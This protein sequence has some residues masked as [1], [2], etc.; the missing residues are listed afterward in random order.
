M[1]VVIQTLASFNATNLVFS[2][3]GRF[4]PHKDKDI[5][6]GGEIGERRGLGREKLSGGKMC[7]IA[8]IIANDCGAQLHVAEIRKMCSQIVYR[9]PDDEGFYVNGPVGLGMRRLSIIDVSG[10]QQPIHNED[11]SVWVVFNGEIYNFIELRRELQAQGHIFYT[12]SD[13]EVIVHAYEAYGSDCVQRLRGM[14]AF[15]LYDFRNRKLLLARD[16]LG[17]KPLHYAVRNGILYFA[18]EIK[19]L[20]AVVP[21]FAMVDRQSIAQFFYFGYIPDPNT[22]FSAVRKLPPGYWLEF[23]DTTIRLEQYWDLPQF[24]SVVLPEFECLQQLENTFAE[25][26]RIRLM[27]EVPLGA[28]LSGGVDSSTVVAMMAKVSTKP[29][30]TFSIRFPQADFNE[31][32]HARSVASRFETEHHELEVN[33]DLWSTLERLTSIIDEPFADSSVIPTYHVA[34]MARDHVTVV[35]SG[36]GGDELFAGYDN[37]VINYRRR[38]LDFVPN[39]VGPMYHKFVYPRIPIK[40]RNRKLVYTFVLGS[41]E[42]FVE[43]KSSLPVY[44]P[45]LTVLSPEFVS[46]IA[47]EDPAATIRRYYDNAPASDLVSRMQYVDAKTYLT[48]DVLT[49]VDRMSMACSLEVRC[50][51]LDHVFVELAARI[52]ISMKLRNGTRKYL[53]RRLAEKLGVPRETLYRRKQGFALPLKHWMRVEMK[54]EMT[55]VL[56]EP[57][58]LQR[59]YFRKGAVERMLSE[60]HRGE[61]DHAP[62]LWQLLMFEFWHRNYLER[63]TTPLFTHTSN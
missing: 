28:L 42:R 62:A 14:F 21:E 26:V 43:G 23:S 18:S 3:D 55:A 11:R 1:Q 5:G 24:S 58:T 17:K 22:I 38:Y 63:W 54:K 10:G 16:R 20:L 44:D 6:N 31:A 61:R 59:G 34:R 4:H 37:Y 41:R 50:P 49:K 35:L 13:T 30:K 56:L 25:A 45:D 36:D 29:V 46:A 8:G 33:A 51:L 19:S 15:A 47:A 9:G 39:W 12:Q 53:L 40:L 27:S 60:H 2:E 48:A 32:S 57:R 7:G 52:P